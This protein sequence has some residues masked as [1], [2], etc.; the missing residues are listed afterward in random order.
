MDPHLNRDPFEVSP[1]MLPDRNGVCEIHASVIEND[2]PN[3]ALTSPGKSSINI[4]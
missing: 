4:V 1:N 2:I 3:G